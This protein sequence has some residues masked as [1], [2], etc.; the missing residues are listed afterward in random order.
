[1]GNVTEL[2]T[3]LENSQLERVRV[4]KQKTQY[5]VQG[6]FKAYDV[7]YIIHCVLA[8]NTQVAGQVLER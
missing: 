2:V 8:E 4:P 6:N 5:K 7:D 3:G 1:M